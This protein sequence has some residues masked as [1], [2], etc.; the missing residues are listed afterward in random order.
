[1]PYELDGDAPR[2]DVVFG[3]DPIH[4]PEWVREEVR[5]IVTAA[6]YTFGVNRP[7][8]GTVVPLSMYGDRRVT[9]FMLEINRATYMD[10]EKTVRG[11][12]FEQ[13]RSLIREIAEAVS[14]AIW[15]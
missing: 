11:K 6:G 15:K 1:L 8:A 14:K 13:V 3:D 12:G 4:T 5:R 9:S 10:E 2:A 7:F